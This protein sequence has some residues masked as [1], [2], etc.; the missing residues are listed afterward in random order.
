M[1][2]IQQTA[3]KHV[4]NIREKLEKTFLSINTSR[5]RKISG[6]TCNR[7]NVSTV[8]FLFAFYWEIKDWYKH[9]FLLNFNIRL[10]SRNLVPKPKP[11]LIPEDVNLDPVSCPDRNSFLHIVKIKKERQS[12][13]NGRVGDSLSTMLMSQLWYYW[14]W[15]H[16]A[17]NMQ[18]LMLRSKVF[19]VFKVFSIVRWFLKAE[20]TLLV[21]FS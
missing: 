19:K 7:W 9:Q 20:K 11:I 16:K 1:A 15:R 3:N 2:E 21:I 14:F 18:L 17:L 4:N 8:H 12:S 6:F 13:S 10:Y 5:F